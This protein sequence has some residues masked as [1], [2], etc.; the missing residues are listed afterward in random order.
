MKEAEPAS[1]TLCPLTNRQ[2]KISNNISQ[3]KD[4]PSSI[5]FFFNKWVLYIYDARQEGPKSMEITFDFALLT[6]HEIWTTM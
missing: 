4:V 5:L 6:K 3:F 1:E 2:C